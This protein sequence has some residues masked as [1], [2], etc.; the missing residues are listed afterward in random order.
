MTPAS[1]KP[2]MLTGVQ[3][4]LFDK[5]RPKPTASGEPNKLTGLQG[6]NPIAALA[7]TGVQA[8]FHDAE[9]APKLW[10]SNEYVPRAMVDVDTDF[11]IDAALSCFAKI[12]DGAALNPSLAGLRMKKAR[13]LKFP[14]PS[15]TK[16]YLQTARESGGLD[17][18]LASALTCEGPL[19]GKEDSKQTDFY[20]TAGAQTFLDIA[21][22]VLTSVTRQ[23][24]L[25]ALK[26]P[27]DYADA[28]KGRTFMWDSADDAEFTALKDGRAKM[29]NAG[30]EALALIGL[31]YYPVFGV[32]GRR[33]TSTAG[34]DGESASRKSFIWPLW[35]SP[36][37]P[38]V[39]R[40]IISAAYD[41]E[42]NG[43]RMGVFR[44]MRS[45]IRRFGQGYG[46]FAP[47]TVVWERR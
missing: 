31:A 7:A 42:G 41:D 1:N 16:R 3:G 10:W 45:R 38:E 17:A 25:T 40:V 12:A 22:N 37:S 35:D 46:G 11:I 24:L 26:G 34:C 43:G 36:A 33:K 30:V 44:V 21:K 13:A 15:D 18:L 6:T 20:F 19:S 9:R 8:L 23:R 28:A 32:G 27:W 4:S 47:P 2:N 14:T 39:T 5:L 29:T